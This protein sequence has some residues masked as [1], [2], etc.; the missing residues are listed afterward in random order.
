MQWQ[1]SIWFRLGAAFWFVFCGWTGAGAVF[2]LSGFRGPMPAGWLF[3]MFVFGSLG[4]LLQIVAVVVH[5]WRERS[6]QW[7]S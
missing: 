1:R 2:G 3:G 7:D 6:G 4:I 5:V